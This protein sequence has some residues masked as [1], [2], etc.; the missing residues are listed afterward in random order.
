MIINNFSQCWALY[1]LMLFYLAVHNELKPLNP[2]RKF[3]TIKLV[4]FASFWQGLAI[5]LLAAF[6]VLKPMELR[7]GDALAA[8]EI[9]G[10]LQD[11]LICIEMFFSAVGFAW[12]FPPRDYM[13]GEPP[14]FWQSFYVL[15]DL[16]DVMDD[17][18]G[19]HCSLLC[20]VPGFNRTLLH[21][22]P[23]TTSD[24]GM[25]RTRRPFERE[26]LV[27]LLQH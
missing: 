21:T 16:T 8:K 6:H 27:L 13:T 4:V 7:A 17:V 18:Q 23:F 3:V 24:I 5:T 25:H 10:G 12:A 22:L 20:E 11:F 26:V 14:G 9:T 2:F 15:F 1:V 19:M